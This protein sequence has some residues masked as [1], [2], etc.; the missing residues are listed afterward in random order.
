MVWNSLHSS[1]PTL[2]TYI[3]ST[4]ERKKIYFIYFNLFICF[5]LKHIKFKKVNKNFKFYGKLKI[6]I[7]QKRR[8]SFFFKIKLKKSNKNKLK[9]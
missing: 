6:K 7:C 3:I 8:K 2:C 1:T 4:V 5:D 9:Q